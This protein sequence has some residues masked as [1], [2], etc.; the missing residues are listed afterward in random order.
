M[1]I[2]VDTREQTPYLFNGFPVEVERGTLNAGDYSITGFQDEIAIERKELG[3][4]LGC[5]TH[6]RDRFTRELEKLRGYQSAALLVESPFSFIQAGR[7]RSHMKPDAAVQSL[8]SIMQHYRMPIFFAADRDAGE[9]FV[10]DFLRHF[11]RHATQR[12][13]AIETQT[14]TA[15]GQGEQGTTP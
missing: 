15:T 14:L 2:I 11:I 6:D 9:R 10:Y 3:D 5:L 13:K 4:L 7:Y 12:Y 8:F 1:R